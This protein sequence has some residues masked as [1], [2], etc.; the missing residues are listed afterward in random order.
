ML[1]FDYFLRSS[2]RCCRSSWTSLAVFVACK[3]VPGPKVPK[4]G[5]HSR[6]SVNPEGVG[7]SAARDTAGVWRW[8]SELFYNVLS[9]VASQSGNC[10]ASPAATQHDWTWVMVLVSVPVLQ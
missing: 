4:L 10:R 1:L 3:R 6:K 7:D 9:A 5:P 2:T 8:T